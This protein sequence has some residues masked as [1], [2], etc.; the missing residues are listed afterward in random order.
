[1]LENK[2]GDKGAEA[3]AQSLRINTSLTHLG[4]ECINF[5]SLQFHPY[6]LKIANKISADGFALLGGG[7]NKNTSL[8]SLYLGG[9]N[10]ICYLSF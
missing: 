7:L 10:R 3:L 5:L 2:I 9:T 6:K 8:R 4:L 1:L